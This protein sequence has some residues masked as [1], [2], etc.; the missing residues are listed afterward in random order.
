MGPNNGNKNVLAGPAS[1]SLRDDGVIAS[2]GKH[3]SPLLGVLPTGLAQRTRTRL[4][5]SCRLPAARLTLS[6]S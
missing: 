4:A 1:E 2:I 5:L 6:H 3:L